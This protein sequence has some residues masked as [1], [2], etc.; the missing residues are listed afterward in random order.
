[1]GITKKQLLDQMETDEI[2]DELLEAIDDDSE[3]EFEMIIEAW[4]PL[5]MAPTDV[6]VMVYYE[7]DGQRCIGAGYFD[8]EPDEGEKAGWVCDGD[9]EAT[10]LAWRP[11][12]APPTDEDLAAFKESVS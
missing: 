4:L 12:P 9:E 8:T 6:Q 1:M 10:P 7:A 11:F 2:M 3:L 5:H